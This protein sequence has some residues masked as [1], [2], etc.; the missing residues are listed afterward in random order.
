ML[1]NFLGIKMAEKKGRPLNFKISSYL[2]T[3]LGKD[4]ITDDYVAIF[5]LVKNSF[6]AKA[7]KV[8]L[9]FDGD[10]IYIID[11]GKGMSRSDILEKWIFVAFSAKREGEE[12]VQ[13]DYRGKIS[14]SVRYA[15]SKGVGRFSCDRLGASLLMQTKSVESDR[16]Q[17]VDV[18]WNDFESSSKK[19]FAEVPIYSRYA[20]SFDLPEWID[21]PSNSGTILKISNLRSQWPREKLLELKS[22][23]SKLINPFG[24]RKKDFSI[25]IY[26]EIEK[27][28]DSRVIKKSE[29]LEDAYHQIVNGPIENFIFETLEQ[30]TTW[31]KTWIDKSNK[32][33]YTELVDRGRLIYKVSEPLAYPDLKGSGYETHIYYLNRSA[34]S[35]FARR[36]GV[37]SADFGSVFLFKN[38][39]RVYPVGDEGDDSFKIDRRK[40]QG[41]ARY[42]GT[43]DIL[44]R[45]DIKG[46][47]KVFRES[48]SRDKGLIET[49]AYLQLVDCFW[50]KTL[51]RL[52]NYVVGVSWKLKYDQDMEDSS[53]L[54]GDEAKAKVID[55]VA[56][57]CNSENVRIEKYAKDILTV[58]NNKIDGFDKTIKNLESL[59]E[60]VG[61]SELVLRAQEAV[62][63]YEE[64]QRVEA[65]AIAF[66]ERERDARVKAEQIAKVATA[67]LKTKNKQL[68]L[69]KEKNLFYTSQQNRDK[70]ILE[71]LHHQII[72]HASNAINNIEA[73]LVGIRHGV[74]PTKDELKDEFSN[75]LF[76]MQQVI[77]ASRFATSANFK[78][79]SSHITEDLPNFVQQYIERICP[80]F[81]SRAKIEVINKA[82][83]FVR[84]FKPI[85]ISIIFDN[86]IDNACKAGASHIRIHIES[87]G[88]NSVKITFSDD[89]IGLAD[90]FDDPEAIFQKGVT[91]TNGSGIG[92]Y[93][94]RQI[95]EGMNGNIKVNN[96]FVDGLQ[97]DIRVYK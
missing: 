89:G 78:M 72:I 95:L 84:R 67:E 36:M 35:T 13:S 11:N 18:N 82:K 15:G 73:N 34:K 77:A 44:G 52:E 92:L 21:P 56:R 97:F 54:T 93:N 50:N 40:Q 49:S 4:L 94:V 74:I 37:S 43:R 38:G 14:P 26:S 83:G 23:L 5:E 39:F 8:K 70:D 41:Y 16:V 12:D 1:N 6:D 64:M 29:S 71:N 48:S 79:E 46:D 68:Q 76:I 30:K 57:L 59:A 91:S 19:E 85:E 10:D 96:E 2:K 27:K 88:S 81:E 24:N 87:S 28:L 69:E 25:E 51:L 3:I 66:A 60:K 65:E 90:T 20:N 31:I 58:I 61:D 45:I 33:I 7:K 86:L 47:E 22:A 62:S 63:K 80:F 55:V 53:F 42:L 17:I 32:L 75:L 9:C